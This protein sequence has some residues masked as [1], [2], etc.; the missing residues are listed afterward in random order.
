MRYLT[1][2]FVFGL[3]LMM[4]AEA[5]SPSDEMKLAQLNQT[6]LE[7]DGE[8]KTVNKHIRALRYELDEAEKRKNGRIIGSAVGYSLAT[9]YS[10]SAIQSLSLMS[11]YQS[12]T[13]GLDPQT[14]A[15]IEDYY[16]TAIRRT[17]IGIIAPTV[18]GLLLGVVQKTALNN[19]ME[20]I[21]E[22]RRELQ[23]KELQRVELQ[24]SLNTHLA[25]KREIQAQ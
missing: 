12:T 17:W 22:Y 5:L 16:D 23:A 2:L 24:T 7:I 3:G 25:Q 8:L 11:Q 20:L 10:T 6:I 18:G 13:Q 21:K 9:I 14:A 4:D 15:T 19:E 1:L